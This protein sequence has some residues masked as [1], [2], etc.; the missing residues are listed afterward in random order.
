MVPKK[1]PRIPLELHQIKAHEFYQKRLASGKEG[2]EIDDWQQAK[3]YFSQHPRAIFAWNLKMPYRGGKRLIKRL[4]LSL[5]SLVRVAWKLLIFPFWLFQQ[6]PGLFAREDKDSRTFAIEVVKTIIS[7]LGLIATLL[8]GIGLFLNY[9]NSQAERQLIQERLITERFSKAVEQIGNTKE[10]VV[11]GGIYSLERIAKDSPKDQWTIMEVLTSYIRKNSPI[12]SNIEQLEPEER[13]KALEKLPSVSIPVQAALTVIGRRKG[14]NLA[15]TTDSNKI[16]ILD[17]SRTNLSGA[18]LNGANLNRANLNRA[19]LNVANLKGAYLKE[20]N[21]N[22]ASLGFAKLEGARLNGADLNRADLKGAYLNRA[23][24]NGAKLEGAQLNRAYLNRAN[25]N[26]ANLN[27]AYLD[28]ANLNGAKLKG[29]DLNLA[30]LDGAYLDG[31]YL[32]RAILFGARDLHPEQIKSACFWERAIHTQAKWDKDK[33]LWVA[34]DP[35]ANQREIDKLKRDKNSDLPN[36]IDC[37][38]K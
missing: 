16:K 38:T 23:N 26:G 20:A 8:A 11:I 18:N 13:Q 12:P 33:Q 24:L 34:A 22:R 30:Y 7:A 31:A 17:L 36:P 21:L 15:E 28:G 5:Q 4:L 29:A 2:N 25:L 14:D 6:I 1:S 10:E 32:N 35:K 27:L 19:Y 3:E 9:L 37:N